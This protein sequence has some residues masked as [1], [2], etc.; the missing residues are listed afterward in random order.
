M[1]D[2]TVKGREH[3]ATSS[4]ETELLREASEDLDRDA[5]FSQNQT[6]LTTKVTMPVLGFYYKEETKMT[7]MTQSL[8]KQSVV[9]Q[10]KHLTRCAADPPLRNT[11]VRKMHNDVG[12]DT[13][14]PKKLQ[15]M[16]YSW[17]H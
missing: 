15:D 12:F 10:H 17:D 3:T 11:C 16:N 7:C 2:L 13:S 9:L 8:P 1:L 6:S 5:D 4:I 14:T